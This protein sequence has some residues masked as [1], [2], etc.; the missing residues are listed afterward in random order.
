MGK[1][2]VEKRKVIWNMIEKRE[3]FKIA[4]KMLNYASSCGRYSEAAL[5]QKK[6]EIAEL[7]REVQ[8]DTEKLSKAIEK[9]QC[10]FDRCVLEEHYLGCELL[11]VIAS[12]HKCSVTKVLRAQ[13]RGLDQLDI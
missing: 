3:D 11:L 12:R 9:V 2:R 13:A 5:A 6:E 1:N 4:E 7:R 10:Y 8:E